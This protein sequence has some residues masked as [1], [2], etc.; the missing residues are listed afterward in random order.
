[1]AGAFSLL[2]PEKSNAHWFGPAPALNLKATKVRV[3]RWTWRT[4]KENPNENQSKIRGLFADRIGDFVCDESQRTL[5]R[6]FASPGVATL[7]IVQVVV[8]AAR[9]LWRDRTAVCAFS[10]F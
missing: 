5:P 1:M 7:R 9:H 3:I 4:D 8:A 2:G 6:R 10:V